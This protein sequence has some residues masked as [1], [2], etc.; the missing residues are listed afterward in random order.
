MAK[1]K[2]EGFRFELNSIVRYVGKLFDKLTGKEAI[3]V[4]RSHSKGKV[5]YD[6]KFIHD[7]KVRGFMETVLVE[8][9]VEN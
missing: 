3:V 6:L 9:I 1:R 7:E 4:K 2:E 8:V 5:N